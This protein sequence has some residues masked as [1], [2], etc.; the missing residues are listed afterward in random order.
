MLTYVEQPWTHQY[1]PTIL[2]A[3]I[4]RNRNEGGS[5]CSRS[6]SLH[7]HRQ[8]WRLGTREISLRGTRP[9]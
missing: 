9:D 3:T 5:P 6:V 1:L 8:D 7:R 2:A 4:V